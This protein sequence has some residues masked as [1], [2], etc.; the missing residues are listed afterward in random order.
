MEMSRWVETI[1]RGHYIGVSNL[2]SRCSGWRFCS[3]R[4]TPPWSRWRSP[5]RPCWPSA[6][7]TSASC[8]ERWP[9]SCAW[10]YIWY[11][12]SCKQVIRVMHS[13][14]TTVQLPKDGQPD[15]GLTKDYGNSGLH[16]YKTIRHILNILVGHLSE[17]C[18][19]YFILSSLWSNV[20]TGSRSRA[21]KTTRTSTPHQPPSTFQ[22]S[23]PLLRKTTWRR[24]SM[25]STWPSRLEY[26]KFNQRA[27]SDSSFFQAFK[28][29][30]KD[31]KMALVQLPTVE[32]SIT[33]LVKL[34]N[35]QLSETSHLRFSLLQ[36]FFLILSTLSFSGS[37]SRKAQSKGHTHR[38]RRGAWEYV[39][40]RTNCAFLKLSVLSAI[41]K[42]YN[43]GFMQFL[44]VYINL[45]LGPSWS[46]SLPW[47]PYMPSTYLF[48]S[49]PKIH[50]ETLSTLKCFWIHSRQPIWR[51]IFWVLSN[52][53]EN[54]RYN[55]VEN[56][57]VVCIIYLYFPPPMT[58]KCLFHGEHKLS[59]ISA[60]LDVQF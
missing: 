50:Q 60:G 39:N 10:M 51:Q 43:T 16:R 44:G 26:A 14:H 15:A 30:P 52:Q 6:T 31:R 37:P 20:S 9:K 12:I 8:G 11:F 5:S 46:F 13:K 56:D 49:P 53:L 57:Y 1:S 45:F 54:L 29:F 22:T 24:L 55:Q 40:A 58:A 36:P 18:L 3:T 7:S 38:R 4:R 34:H 21:A 23:P 27:G 25:P 2:M 19:L 17:K 35:F 28:F 48:Q 47:G 59:L 33:A 32:E 41:S 42:Y